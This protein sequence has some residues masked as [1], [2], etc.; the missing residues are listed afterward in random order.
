MDNTGSRTTKVLM[1]GKGKI[2]EVGGTLGRSLSRRKAL[3]KS[4][5]IVLEEETICEDITQPSI[6]KNS[7]LLS[8]Q[9]KSEQEAKSHE[10][11]K[12]GS[13]RSAKKKA[14]WPPVKDQSLIYESG[15]FKRKTKAKQI[16]K[17]I[18]LKKSKKGVKTKG[19]EGLRKKVA[20]RIKEE[21]APLPKKEEM[22]VKSE[23]LKKGKSGSN[24]GN[25]NSLEKKRYG[26]HNQ[27]R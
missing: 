12:S 17:V 15:S 1:K 25:Q 6:S 22:L 3:S 10:S 27:C 4:K 26:A 21:P 19:R 7:E 2:V 8:D 18:P 13:D 5:G 20:K 24:S 9:V 11:S 14:D 23:E 16:R